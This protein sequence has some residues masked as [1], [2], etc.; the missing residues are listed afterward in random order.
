MKVDI[1]DRYVKN[2][3]WGYLDNNKWVCERESK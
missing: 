2:V 3:T 1:K